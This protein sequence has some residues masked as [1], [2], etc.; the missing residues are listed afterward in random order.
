MMAACLDSF[1]IAEYYIKSGAD[2]DAHNN[3]RVYIIFYKFYFY[4]FK[5]LEG[6]CY[7]IDVSRESRL[8]KNS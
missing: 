1:R 7:S 6:K 4:F 8:H 2:V 5:T 3:V